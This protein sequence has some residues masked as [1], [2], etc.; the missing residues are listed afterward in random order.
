MEVDQHIIVAVCGRPVLYDTTMVSYRDRNKTERAWVDVA[1]D[2]G[3]PVDVCRRRWKSLRDRYMRYKKNEKEGK[4]SV[5]AAGRV[6]TWRFARVLSFLDPFV[7]PRETSSNLPLGAEEVE[8]DGAPET[9][10]SGAGE[11]EELEQA[12]ASHNTDQPSSESDVEDADA[13]P[14]PVPA[15]GPSHVPVP[16]AAPAPR[17]Q[18]ATK[19]KRAARVP[20]GNTVQ[21]AILQALQRHNS[22]PTPT[23]LSGNE[24]F[25]M[26]LVPSLDRLPPEVLEYVKFQIR[27]VIF[28]QSNFTVQLEPI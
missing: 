7:T 4:K 3:V 8:G 16:E 28:D 24:H 11:D 18:G 25:A 1:E 20:E 19:R 6:D 13:A 23:P 15:V 2:I 12:A 9:P 26:G 10:L 14:A 17:P 5:S 27:K 22:V 21:T